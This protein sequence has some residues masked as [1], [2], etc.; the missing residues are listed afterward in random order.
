MSVVVCPRPPHDP[1]IRQRRS[2]V[3]GTPY[4]L[5]LVHCARVFAAE[6][7]AA[8]LRCR[9]ADCA[10]EGRSR[11]RRDLQSGFLARC[12]AH[13]RLVTSLTDSLKNASN[14][15]KVADISL[16]GLACDFVQPTNGRG[17][18]AR[19]RRVIVWVDDLDFNFNRVS[20]ALHPTLSCFAPFSHFRSIPEK[21]S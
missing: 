21:Y 18:H 17:F 19:F 16:L 2:G 10:G 8:A 3:L 15:L 11:R 5:V 13:A 6:A 4:R 14:L 9:R 20:A 7:T 1:A 12:R